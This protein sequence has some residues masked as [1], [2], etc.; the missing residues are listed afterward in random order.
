MPRKTQRYFNFIRRHNIVKIAY[1]ARDVYDLY[2]AYREDQK[3]AERNSKRIAELEANINSH[4]EQLLNTPVDDYH[5]RSRLRR[6]INRFLW[7]LQR[8]RH[9][10]QN[11]SRLRSNFGQAAVGI[12]TS[13]ISAET[14]GVA[15]GMAG[16]QAGAYAGA[17]LGP[18]GLAAGGAVGGLV[19]SMVG[20]TIMSNTIDRVAEQVNWQRV[21]NLFRWRASG[22]APPNDNA[23]EEVVIVEEVETEQPLDYNEG[24]EVVIEDCTDND[25]DDDGDNNEEEPLCD[26][27]EKQQS[28]PAESS[29]WSS[30]FSSYIW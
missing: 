20:D 22:T 27:G 13:M 7:R 9:R 5:E 17:W 12:V 19:G 25:D 18:V 16:M 29:T 1:L 21:T 15:G 6:E 28:A 24:P 3:M 23:Q 14:G 10:L 4:N 2:G 30:Y 11:R 26:K 8:E